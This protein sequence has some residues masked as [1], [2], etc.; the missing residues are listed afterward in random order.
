[1]T[2]LIGLLGFIIL[3]WTLFSGLKHS[4]KKDIYIS[5]YLG[6]ILV[7]QS[8]KMIAEGGVYSAG[9][10][11]CFILWITIGA[12][13]AINNKSIKKREFI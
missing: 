2:G 12:V 1:M 3:W 8:V 7:H 11:D 13:Q 10:I 6:A 4:E 9:G 5:S